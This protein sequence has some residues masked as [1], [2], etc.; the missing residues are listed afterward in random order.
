MIFER[1]TDDGLSQYSYLLASEETGEAAVVDP[2]RDVEPYLRFARSRGLRIAHVLETHIHADYASGALDLAERTGAR[3]HLSA[4]DDGERYEVSFA[5]RPLRD[6]DELRLGATRLVTRHTPGHTPE[7]L[8]F[9]V[10]EGGDAEPDRILTGDFLFVDSVGR[11][12]LLGEDA[13]RELAGAQ[14][15]SV[16]HVLGGLPD[17][18]RVHPGHGSGSM[19]G[20]GLGSIPESTLGRERGRNPYLDP[21][22]DRDAFVHEL[23][24]SLPPYPDYY[25]RMKERNTGGRGYTR[26]WPE[27]VALD[28]D[29][30]RERAEDGAMVV[31]VR[32][33]LAFGGAHVPGALGIGLGP[34]LSTWAGWVVPPDRPLLLVTDRR[35]DVARAVLRLARVGLDRVEG[36][37]APG[38][39]GWLTAARPIDT[40]PQL[41][42]RALETRLS[43]AG[44]GVLDVRTREEYERGHIEGAVHVMGGWLPDRLDDVPDRDAPIAVICSTGYRSTVAASV[45]QRNGFRQVWN[46]PGGMTAWRA[47]GLPMA[48]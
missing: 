44:V 17:A 28:V 43:D 33:Q 40:T 29:R 15:D 47:A 9:L 21:A 30:F 1:F 12:D 45:L 19:C 25:R 46:V 13:S 34:D 35:D 24:A 5:H 6:G 27:P 42:P 32:G 39:D 10:Y 37:L 3:L 48:D 41:P 22:L 8:S 2:H 20:S 11:P 18:L 7:H 31:D 26:A 14:F 4:Y 16:R 23:L 38:M 36:F